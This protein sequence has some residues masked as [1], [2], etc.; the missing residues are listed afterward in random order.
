MFGSPVGSFTP[1][2]IRF[3][4]S[5]QGTPWFRGA[6]HY[7][8]GEQADGKIQSKSRMALVK[9]PL[10]KLL[11]AF[12]KALMS[13]KA[14]PLTPHK[15]T[16]TFF[17]AFRITH[18]PP[19]EILDRTMGGAHVGCFALAARLEEIRPAL[20]VFGHIHK[21]R[22]AIIKQWDDD[23]SGKRKSTVYVNAAT[24]VNGKKYRPVRRVSPTMG[25]QLLIRFT[26]A[27]C[28]MVKEVIRNSFNLSLS[29]FAIRRMYLSCCYCSPYLLFFYQDTTLHVRACL[30]HHILYDEVQ[31]EGWSPQQLH[32][33]LRELRGVM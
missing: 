19:R 17:Y 20:S 9:T 2:K 8:R 33:H 22:G 29:T 25:Y 32:N 7:A 12:P 15:Q 18:G 21:D 13:C 5:Q 14:L 11:R 3:L 31:E 23:G 4:K 16:P 28:R 10:Q 24:Q 1:P 30:P 6:F 26:S 27:M